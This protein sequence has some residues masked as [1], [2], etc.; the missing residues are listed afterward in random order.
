MAKISGSF[1]YGLVSWES[2]GFIPDFINMLARTKYFK[3]VVLLQSVTS[4]SKP[5]IE[6]PDFYILNT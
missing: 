2:N 1:L 4:F 3:Q 6:P 5:L